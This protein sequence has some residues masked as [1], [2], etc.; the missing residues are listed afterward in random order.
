MTYFLVSIQTLS[1]GQT[2][3]SIAG[4]SALEDA[5]SAYHATLASNYISNLNGF[6]VMIIDQNGVI[7]KK[8]SYIKPEPEEVTE[9]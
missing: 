7:Y 1:T 9:Y 8:E 2:P 5:I 4:Y 6:T 3:S